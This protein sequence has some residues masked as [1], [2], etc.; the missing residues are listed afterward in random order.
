MEELLAPLAQAFLRRALLAGTLQRGVRQPVSQLIPLAH[1]Q[2]E[3]CREPNGIQR[4]WR[5][6]GHERRL[7]FIRGDRG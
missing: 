2:R 6:A 5:Q 7:D 4:A 3:Q 1:D